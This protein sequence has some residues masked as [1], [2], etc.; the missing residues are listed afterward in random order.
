[1]PL[2]DTT[3]RMSANAINAAL[4]RLGYGGEQVAH[5]FRATARTLLDEALGFPAHLIEHQLAHAV[6]DPLG[7]AYNRTA[8]LPERRGMMQAW[9]DYLDGLKNGAE[10]VPRSARPG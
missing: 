6:R 1:M 4:G 3:I 8:H 2:T 5:S 10:V 9:A 7:R